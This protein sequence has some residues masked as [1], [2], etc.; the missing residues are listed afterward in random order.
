MR[1]KTLLLT[2]GGLAL[3]SLSQAD[4]I[5]FTCSV[6]LGAVSTSKVKVPI[7]LDD[8]K[9]VSYQETWMPTTVSSIGI[10]RNAESWEY[11]YVRCKQTHIQLRGTNDFLPL[12]NPGSVY[13][14]SWQPIKD[15]QRT[16]NVAYEFMKYISNN[17]RTDAER[18]GIFQIQVIFRYSGVDQY[19]VRHDFKWTFAMAQMANND[20]SSQINY[21]DLKNALGLYGDYDNLPDLMNGMSVNKDSFWSSLF[22]PQQESIDN[23]VNTCKNW[24]NWGPFGVFTAVNTSFQEGNIHTD[25]I[26]TADNQN[27]GILQRNYVIWFAGYPMD[28]SAYRGLIQFVRLLMAGALWIIAMFAVWKWIGKKV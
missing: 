7:S 16:L 2:L 20:G 27:N 3:C 1:V 4:N 19:L 24:A 13:D 15:L 12:P 6:E 23:L 18:Y 22:V 10:N 11:M 26:N 25:S 17:S 8:G 14:L 5:P 28:L 21:S 9:S